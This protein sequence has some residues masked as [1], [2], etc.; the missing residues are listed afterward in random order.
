M[1]PPSESWFDRLAAKP[2]TR[3]QG[4][5]AA[6]LGTAAAVGAGLPFARSLPT[7]SADA[8]DC[9]KGCVY[10]ANQQYAERSRTLATGY[11]LFNT[12]S[13]AILTGPLG[14]AA[15][16]YQL[17]VS[18]QQVRITDEGV[19]SH[20]SSVSGCFKPGCSGFDPFASGGPC[21]NCVGE[22]HCN[23]CAVE[24]IGYVCCVYAP[25]DCHG[26][27]CPTTVAPGCP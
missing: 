24:E 14:P 23:P 8:N 15:F 20:R 17:F 7:A 4:I 6:A 27:C 1:T 13:S 5:K 16:I 10:V 26:D 3:R 12:S 9:R 21:E 25:K 2:H 11:G 19:A 18:K 22:F